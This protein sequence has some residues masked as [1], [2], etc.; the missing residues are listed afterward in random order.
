[1]ASP[2][3]QLEK[4]GPASGSGQMAAGVAALWTRTRVGWAGMNLQQRR[5]SVVSVALLAGLLGW[6]LWFGLRTD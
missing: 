2:Q 4:R 6:L 1:M 5:W 3:M